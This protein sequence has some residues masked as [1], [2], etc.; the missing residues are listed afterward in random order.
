M[1]IDR[2]PEVG[3]TLCPKLGL[4]HGINADGRLC[5]LFQIDIDGTGLDIKVLQLGLVLYVYIRGEL[6]LQNIPAVK[7]GI[8]A[9]E[10]G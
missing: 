6:A 5:L 4:V 8:A 9:K 10:D 2:S 3:V 1:G 7:Y